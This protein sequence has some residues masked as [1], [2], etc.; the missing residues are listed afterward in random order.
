MTKP[1]LIQMQPGVVA[2]DHDTLGKYIFTV[3]CGQEVHPPE[4]IFTENETNFKVN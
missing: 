4:M 1:K 3:D 2:C